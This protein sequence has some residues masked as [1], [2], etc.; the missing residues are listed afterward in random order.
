[1]PSYL[2]LKASKPRKEAD[3]SP[4]LNVGSQTILGSEKCMQCAGR[5]SPDKASDVPRNNNQ[6]RER[7]LKGMSVGRKR[8][9]VSRDTDA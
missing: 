3:C 7:E 2:A 4:E 9:A 6:E 1:M 8:R 5:K